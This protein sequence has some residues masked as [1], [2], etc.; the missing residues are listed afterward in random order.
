VDVSQI[1][2][3][4]LVYIVVL[5]VGTPRDKNCGNESK[6]RL[7]SKI[8]LFYAHIFTPLI[9]DQKHVNLRMIFFFAGSRER[10]VI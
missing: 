8:S 9:F 10:L 7:M 3:Q 5:H 6:I 2:G 1:G 4:N